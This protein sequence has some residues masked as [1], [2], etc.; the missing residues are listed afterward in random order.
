MVGRHQLQHLVHPP[1]A[2][3]DGAC[4]VVQIY[5]Q[6]QERFRVQKSVR[7]SAAMLDPTTTTTSLYISHDIQVMTWALWPL[8]MITMNSDEYH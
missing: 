2:G 3:N 8:N 6:L 1:T 4:C 7:Y 5:K